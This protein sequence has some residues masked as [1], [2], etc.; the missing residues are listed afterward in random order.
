MWRILTQ[1][2]LARAWQ[3]TAAVQDWWQIR[4]DQNETS[5]LTNAFRQYALK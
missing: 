5:T 4:A 1:E 3:V 2:S